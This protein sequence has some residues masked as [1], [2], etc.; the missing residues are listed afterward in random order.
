M[1]QT[2]PLTGQSQQYA[3]PLSAYDLTQ[4][5]LNAQGNVTSSTKASQ[6]PQA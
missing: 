3:L 2:Q 6:Q 4:I 5:N 1:N